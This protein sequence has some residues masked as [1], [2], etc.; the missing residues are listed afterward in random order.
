MQLEE[1]LM[2]LERFC[3][4]AWRQHG[5]DDPMCQLSFNEFDYLK[6]IEQYPQGIRITDLAQEL[7]VT[8]P[9][10]SNMVARLEKK[11]LVRRVACMEDARAKRVILTDWVIQNMSFERVVYQ[12]IAGDLN[13]QLNEQEAQQLVELLNKALK[14]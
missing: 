10:A 2:D 14:K 4:K 3:S 6:V 1:S 11:N 7:Y 9:S 8:K 12:Q 5:N 13:A